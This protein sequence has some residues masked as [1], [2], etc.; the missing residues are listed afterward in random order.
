M[1]NGAS[2][3]TPEFLMSQLNQLLRV[4][5]EGAKKGVGTALTKDEF[6]ENYL[7]GD[8]DPAFGGRRRYYFDYDFGDAYSGQYYDEGGSPFA[9]NRTLEGARFYNKDD[10]YS[11][12]L[13]SLGG[14]F[15]QVQANIFDPAS[16]LGGIE[17]A[18]G[19]GSANKFS[20]DMFTPFTI[21]MFKNLRTEEY[22]PIIEE[23][24]SSFIDD[25]MAG[26]A[27]VA[28][29]DTGVAGS[30]RRD[31]ARQDLNRQYTQNVENIYSDI[32]GQKASALQNLLDVASQY[33]NLTGA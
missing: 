3:L 4:D 20:P 18:Q 9:A 16:F 17:K 29:M 1:A 11:A 14:D 19:I 24:R 15:G 25:L 28:S 5:R 10:A 31:K 32:Q 30:G 12:Y 33:D 6:E 13:D 27:N 23:G 26:K 7:S 21:D 22:Q 2:Y 8:I